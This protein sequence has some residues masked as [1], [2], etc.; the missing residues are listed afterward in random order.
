[1]PQDQGPGL[2]NKFLGPLEPWGLSR[3]AKS[4]MCSCREVT[5]WTGKMIEEMET[6]FCSGKEGQSKVGSI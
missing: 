3:Q 1:M 2:D 4:E 6:S 5:P